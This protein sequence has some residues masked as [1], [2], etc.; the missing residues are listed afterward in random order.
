MDAQTRGDRLL[1]ALEHV[2]GELEKLRILRE[3]EMGVRMVDEEGTLL[4]KPAEK[5]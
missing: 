4:V 1:E 5:G 2:A 3:H